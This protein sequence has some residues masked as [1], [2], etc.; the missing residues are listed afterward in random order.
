MLLVRK[1]DTASLQTLIS[2]LSKIPTVQTSGAATLT[3]TRNGEELLANCEC[4][5]LKEAVKVYKETIT[6]LREVITTQQ[7]TINREEGKRTNWLTLI[8]WV[9][10]GALLWKAM[11][12]ASKFIK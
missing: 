8:K 5:E 7:Q 11:D 4:S 2:N 9:V 10:I 6:N 12:I 1:A 3:L